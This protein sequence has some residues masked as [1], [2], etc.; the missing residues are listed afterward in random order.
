MIPTPDPIGNIRRV[1]LREVWAHEAHDFTRWLEQNLNVLSEALDLGL[2]PVER[3]HAAGPFSVD[4][5]A[6]DESSRSVVIENQL[7]KSDH[8]HLGKVLTYLVAVGAGAAVWIVA[9]PRPEHVAAVAWLNES[10][11]A[12]FYLVKLEAIRIGESVPA[13]LFTL[14]VGPSEEVREAARTKQELAG[15]F[16][17][18]HRYWSALLE[19]A[20]GRTS[21][22]ASISPG[23]HGWLG[24][25]AG[26]QGV[27]YNYTVR[28]HDGG[29]ELYI[30]R[31]A[32]RAEENAAIFEA[33]LV[34]KEEIEEAFGGTLEWMPLEN[35]RACR[36]RHRTEA[37]G[38]RD[39]DAWPAAHEE[40]VDAMVRMERALR[41]HLQRLPV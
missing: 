25:G 8:D 28:Q 39:E 41:P 38:Y 34:H 14:I 33:L 6:E 4:L 11:T 7:E 24:T 10:S 15:R 13:P 29:V 16:A 37:G 36:I 35:K 32:A 9:E 18:R 40:M 3:E 27:G 12:D 30:D 21:L 23:R 2:S 1:P 19:R 20:K 5:V 17:E 31:G 22:H 26:R